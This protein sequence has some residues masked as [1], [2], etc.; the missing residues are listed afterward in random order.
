MYL[1]HRSSLHCRNKPRMEKAKP[2]DLEIVCGE[3][4]V[5]TENQYSSPENEVNKRKK[6]S[7]VIL[8][9]QKVF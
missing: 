4:S 7:K 3:V 9:G 1:L 8:T 5:E 6:M 2:E